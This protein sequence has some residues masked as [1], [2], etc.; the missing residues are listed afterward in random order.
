[1]GEIEN[2]CLV[3]EAG[4]TFSLQIREMVENWTEG[5]LILPDTLGETENFCPATTQHGNQRLD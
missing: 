5:Q 2:I 3:A 4:Q 1:L